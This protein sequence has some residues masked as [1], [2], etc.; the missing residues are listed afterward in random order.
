MIYAKSYYSLL[1][2]MLSPE[3]IINYAFSL[4]EKACFLV[5]TNLYGAMYFYKKCISKKIKPIIGLH[6]ILKD[7]LCD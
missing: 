1:S 5:D 7:W 2:S 3:D 6:V 4:S